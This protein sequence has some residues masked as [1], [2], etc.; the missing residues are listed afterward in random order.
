LNATLVGALKTAMM[1]VFALVNRAHPRFIKH[2]HHMQQE[3]K[4][5]LLKLQIPMMMND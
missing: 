2:F 4:K 3:N 1:L 5:L